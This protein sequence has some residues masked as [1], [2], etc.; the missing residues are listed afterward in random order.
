M[1]SL[2][3]IFILLLR[4]LSV[5]SFHGY[6]LELHVRVDIPSF[7]QETDRHNRIR[8]PWYKKTKLERCRYLKSSS[9]RSCRRAT[10]NR[11]WFSLYCC[12]WILETQTN[13]RARGRSR[14]Y[15]AAWKDRGMH[16]HHKA[17][18]ILPMHTTRCFLCS[19]IRPR[20]LLFI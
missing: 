16:T 2:S 19:C 11:L 8:P 20:L 13:T 5:Y 17:R 9:E 12:S 1:L 4:T 3:F 15:T 6:R 7:P 10:E 14:A 18:F